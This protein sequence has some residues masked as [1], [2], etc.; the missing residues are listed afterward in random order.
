MSLNKLKLMNGIELI[1]LDNKILKE[2]YEILDEINQV[3]IISAVDLLKQKF[4]TM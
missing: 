3:K 2:K 4:L 1:S